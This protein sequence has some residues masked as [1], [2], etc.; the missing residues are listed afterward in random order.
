MALAELVELQAAA[1][2]QARIAEILAVV[3]KSV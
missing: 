2:V 3:V 1:A